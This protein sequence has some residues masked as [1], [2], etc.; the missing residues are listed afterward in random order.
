[1]SAQ[2]RRDRELLNFVIKRGLG[3][4]TDEL[5]DEFNNA[6]GSMFIRRKRL[7]ERFEESE[8]SDA[9]AFLTEE[10]Q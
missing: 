4:S 9:V 6:G 1:M 5:D 7:R 3:Y 10:L 8:H 2:Q